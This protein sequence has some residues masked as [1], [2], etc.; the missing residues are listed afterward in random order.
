M[1]QSILFNDDLVFD[2]SADAWSMTALV[3]GQ[4]VKVYFHS[5]GLKQLDKIDTCTKYDLE[6]VVELW[7]EKHEPEQNEIH[8]EM[9]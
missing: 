3:A 6:E 9:K 7:L 8:I 2:K 4:S 1:N 5:Y